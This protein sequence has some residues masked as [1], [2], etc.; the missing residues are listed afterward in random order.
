MS[1]LP[2]AEDRS[3][4]GEKRGIDATDAGLLR[5]L[6]LDGRRSASDLARELGIS[7]AYANKKLQALLKHKGIRIQA[8]SSPTALGYRAGAMTGIKVLPDGMA[9]AVG[10][11]RSFPGVCQLMITSG[12]EDIVIFTMFPT[13]ADLSAFLTEDLAKIPGI[14]STET[15]II[16]DWRVRNVV[17]E[18]GTGFYSY[19]SFQSAGRNGAANSLKPSPSRQMLKD[20]DLDSNLDLL[21]LTILKEIERDPRQQVSVLAK[22]VGVSQRSASARLRSLIARNVT[23][24]VVYTSPFE[25]GLNFFPMIGMRV[26]PAEVDAVSAKLES[27]PSVFWTVRVSGRYDLVAGTLF[28]G[29]LDVSH[30]VWKELAAIPGVLSLETTIGLE[31]RKWSLPYLASARLDGLAREQTRS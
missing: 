4:R 23:R 3:S 10:A 1:A 26:S 25:V 12:R 16:A 5:G 27:L 18:P 17:S 6:S 30:F 29:P 13:A 20:S 8:F 11:L 15:L 2:T 7:R 24:V 19:L 21:D 22:K 14:Q 9:A 28:A 31:I